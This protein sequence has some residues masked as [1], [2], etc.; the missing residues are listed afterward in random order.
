MSALIETAKLSVARDGAAV[1]NDIS[2]SAGAN[3]MI[4]V[5]G[6]NGAGKTTLLR[7]LVG[8][9]PAASGEARV[10]GEP[11]ASLAPIRRG[12][13]ISYLPQTR[14]IYWS[15]TVERIVA[16]GRF[17]YGAPADLAGEDA[18]AVERAIADADIAHLS[19]RPATSLSGGEAARVH[20]ARALA[21]EAPVLIADEPTAAL[22]PRH[23][24]AIM[25]VLAKRAAAGGLVVAALHDLSLAAR[26]CTRIMLLENGRLTADGAPV[27]VLT[28]ANLARAFGVPA[29]VTAESGRIAVSFD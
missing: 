12:R 9:P 10:M 14:P 8:L 1:L 22:D 2:F 18:A 4:G 15:M 17:A 24:L 23:Q 6:P 13:T 5:I 27:D 16:L 21:A 28:G 26:F 3:E 7:A 19:R 25:K 11:A 29:Q 20:L